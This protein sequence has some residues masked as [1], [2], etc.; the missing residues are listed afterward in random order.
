[1]LQQKYADYGP[2]SLKRCDVVDLTFAR[3][4]AVDARTTFGLGGAR[5]REDRIGI[6][7]FADHAKY[8]QVPVVN[9]H[10]EQVVVRYH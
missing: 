9:T 6:V 7:A 1:M 5:C 8:D 2:E 10:R 4:G 3:I